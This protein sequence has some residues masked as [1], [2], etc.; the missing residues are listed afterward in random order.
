MGPWSPKQEEKLDMVARV[1]WHYYVGGRTQ[2][3]IAK[4]MRM[5]RPTVQRL[6]AVALDR[7][8]VTIRVHHKIGE[9]RTRGGEN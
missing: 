1:A 3:D 7:G 2:N 4:E 9:C 8:I 6:I 5:S